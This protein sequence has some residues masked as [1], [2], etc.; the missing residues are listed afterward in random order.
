MLY[1]HADAIA[2]Y[3][4]HVARHVA[5]ESG[6]TE[7]VFEIAQAVDNTAFRHD[8]VAPARNHA[9]DGAEPKAMYVGRLEAEKG[10]DGLLDAVAL[11]PGLRLLMVGS[12]HELQ[13][14]QRRAEEL[15]IAE[16]VDFVGYV[17]QSE[18]PSVLGAADFLVLPSVTTLRFKETWGL[19][20]NEA[21][22]VGLPV[23]ATEAVGA[24][25]GGLIM[26]GRTGLV[27]PERDVTSLAR[28]LTLLTV[29]SDLRRRLGATAREHVLRWNYDF[30]AEG[31]DAA[32][33][34]AVE[35]RT[36]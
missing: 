33:R 6:R 25:A 13:E 1:R 5:R 24:A 30:A 10:L 28:A 19:V 35:A 18:L 3:G 7:R 27:V 22:N 2:V 36:S 14:L 12:G 8:A 4:P 31:M 34:A 23:I 15:A 29:D 21:M 17:E 20:A 16:R 26:D 9:Q 32:V 11:V